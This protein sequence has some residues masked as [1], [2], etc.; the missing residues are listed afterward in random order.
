MIISTT[1]SKSNNPQGMRIGELILKEFIPPDNGNLTQGRNELTQIN[2]KIHLSRNVLEKNLFRRTFFPDSLS[3]DFN[4]KFLIP[5]SR[6][7]LNHLHGELRY[8]SGRCFSD[9]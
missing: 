1:A 4:N 8:Q 3:I 5:F 2:S 9:Y 7:C 6:Q